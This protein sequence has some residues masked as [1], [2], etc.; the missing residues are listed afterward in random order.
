MMIL[1]PVPPLG[2]R[3]TGREAAGRACGAIDR[4][5]GGKYDNRI[6][7][8][9]AAQAEEW[10]CDLFGVP[11]NGTLSGPDP[12]YDFLWA[13]MRV[14]VKWTPH[15]NGKLLLACDKRNPAD[16]FVFVFGEMDEA[17]E[18]GGWAFLWDFPPDPD[19]AMSHPAYTI[20]RADLRPIADLLAYGRDEEG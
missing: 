8:G 13:A 7:D 3:H 1:P 17:P 11:F 16:V 9:Y 18:I 5:I 2:P 19:P 4:R 15:R 10:V 14:D 12:G 6:N 20:R